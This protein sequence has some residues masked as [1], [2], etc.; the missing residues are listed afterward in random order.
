MT[1]TIRRLALLI[2]LL[3]ASNAAAQGTRFAPSGATRVVLVGS[4]NVADWRCTGRRVDARVEIEASLARITEVLDRIEDGNIS[5]WMTNPEEA[6]FP[7]PEFRL[8]IPIASLSCGNRVME[9]DLSQALKADRFPAIEF[10]FLSLGGPVQRDIDENHYEL[11]VVG[12]I[13]AAGVTRRMSVPVIAQREGRSR[14]RLR[15]HLPLRMTDFGVTP[16]TALL[17]LIKAQNELKVQFDLRL[18]P[19]ILPLEAQRES[20]EPGSGS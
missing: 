10:R 11:L 6:R 17:G 9:K 1:L 15:A 8:S 4:S 7:A 12:E 18:Q 19:V 13:T 3:P 16:P 2:A 14:F 5:A 20:K